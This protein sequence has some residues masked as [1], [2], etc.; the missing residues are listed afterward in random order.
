M[1]NGKLVYFYG[2]V[3]SSKT[4]QLLLTAYNYQT[5]GWTVCTVKP[6]LDTRSDMIETR[7][8]VP[9]R[10]VD[11]VIGKE[12]SFSKYEST[13]NR[14]S[15]ILVDECQFLTTEQVNELRSIAT[16]CHIDVLCFG[17]RT[18]FNTNLFDASKR[19]FELSDKIV[20][21]QTI[22]SVCGK[23]AGFNKLVTKVDSDGNVIPSWD[24]FEQRCYEHYVT[25]E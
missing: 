25:E 6:A 18:D 1:S 19:L 9:S 13:I 8:K 14:A 5:V 3:N 10:K 2:T 20:E 7:A 16:T 4:A 21:V 22:C 15:V 11:I 17:L 23:K 24:A 12:E